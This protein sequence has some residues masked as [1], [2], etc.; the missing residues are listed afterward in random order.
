MQETLQRIEEVIG[1]VPTVPTPVRRT[2]VAEPPPLT[3]LHP[4]P[5]NAPTTPYESTS[6][7]QS[8]RA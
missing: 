8:E 1:L 6:I 7:S 4:I 3:E 5:V 2:L